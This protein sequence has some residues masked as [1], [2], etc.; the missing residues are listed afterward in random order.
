MKKI[1]TYLFATLCLTTACGQSKEQ[2][3]QKSQNDSIQAQVNFD[4]IF[5]NEF[6]ELIADTSV[7]V[8]DVRTAKE[9]AEGHI[10]RAMNID[11]LQEGFL[12]KAKIQLPK[13]K[14]IA[15]YCRSGK[16]SANVAGKLS[17]LG[18]KMVNMKGGIL[19]WKAAEMPLTTE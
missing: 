9:F 17:N 8:L 13:D 14:T 16:R 11:F 12:E 3:A 18:Y 7:V 4:N 2:Q 5:V 15:V 1:L 6:A 19:A 10:K